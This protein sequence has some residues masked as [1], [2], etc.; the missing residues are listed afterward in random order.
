M[1]HRGGQVDVQHWVFGYE[2]N[3]KGQAAARWKVDIRMHA[4]RKACRGNVQ[5][6]LQV[7]RRHA[8]AVA[9]A[10]SGQV[11]LGARCQQGSPWVLPSLTLSASV[12]QASGNPLAGFAVPS[13]L[14]GAKPCSRGSCDQHWSAVF[15]GMPS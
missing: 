10:A 14:P 11:R 3:Y 15:Q 1:V 2:P 12:P 9:M 6:P 13:S 5:W 7:S 4:A 8:L